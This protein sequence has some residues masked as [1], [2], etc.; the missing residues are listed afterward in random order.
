MAR[1]LIWEECLYLLR[2]EASVTGQAANVTPPALP[3]DIIDPGLARVF[4]LAAI[5]Q[6]PSSPEYREI[7]DKLMQALSDRTI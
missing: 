5:N 7:R 1:L 6:G 3:F 2:D 4:M